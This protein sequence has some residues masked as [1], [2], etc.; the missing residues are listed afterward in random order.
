MGFRKQWYLSSYINIPIHG[1][2]PFH[3]ANTCD[4]AHPI[5]IFSLAVT[6][7]Y[8][9]SASGASSIQ[10]HSTT[11]ADFPLAQTIEGA[12]KVGCHHIVVDGRG[13][14][15]VS[16]G[17][18]G[19]VQIWVC[20]DGTWSKDDTAPGNWRYL[21]LILLLNDGTILFLTYSQLN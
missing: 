5:D 18:A 8:I 14:R 19:E 3:G 2:S 1:Q 4:P 21:S 12:H 17:F 10:I 6:D 7:K 11:E 16:V 13:C 9:L 20:R 15:A